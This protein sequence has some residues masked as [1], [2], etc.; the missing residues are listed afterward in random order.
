MVTR[1]PWTPPAAPLRCSPLHYRSKAHW[2]LAVSVSAY[3]CG[4]WSWGC[5]SVGQ[6]C[7]GEWKA[8]VGGVPPR[9]MCVG[10]GTRVHVL[11]GGSPLLLGSRH[12]WQT[13]GCTP[14][15]PPLCRASPEGRLRT[16]K[17]SS[18]NTPLCKA[19]RL[20]PIFVIYIFHNSVWSGFSN[21]L[22]SCALCS[23]II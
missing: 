7:A 22:H 12:P 19:L 13:P 21:L 3:R 6:A 14:S 16:L 17:A 1:A 2:P 15:F 11:S 18:M 4:A 20:H 8:Y 9:G 23:L 5:T 10:V